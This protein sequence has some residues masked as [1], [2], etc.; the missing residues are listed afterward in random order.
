MGAA[1]K[2]TKQTNKKMSVTLKYYII[3]QRVIVAKN[4][5]NQDHYGKYLC[6]ENDSIQISSKNFKNIYFAWFCVIIQKY[7][8][9]IKTNSK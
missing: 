7:T 1:L 3:P 8:L 2:K 9:R 5:C 4:L 6:L